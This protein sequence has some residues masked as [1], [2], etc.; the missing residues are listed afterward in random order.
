MTPIK[1]QKRHLA[2][3]VIIMAIS[4][5]VTGLL[6]LMVAFAITILP[7]IASG[8]IGWLVMLPAHLSVF[9]S[10]VGWVIWGVPIVA[11]LGGA[12][13]AD[14]F[15]GNAGSAAMQR[16]VTWFENSHPIAV[17]TNAYASQLG[18]GQIRYVGWFASDDINAFAMGTE[19][20]DTVI[21]F[22][23][24]AIERLD[25][26][27]FN[28]VIAHEVAHVAN[29]DMHRMTFARGVQEALTFFLV[30]RGLKK[31]AR[32]LFMP[33]AEIEVLRLS[34][35]REFAADHIAAQLTSPQA[36]VSVLETLQ[37]N[38]RDVADPVAL[39]GRVSGLLRTHPPL[40]ARIA[41]I[42]AN[43]YHARIEVPL[44]K[45]VVEVTPSPP[46]ARNHATITLKV[47]TSPT[48]PIAIHGV[49]SMGS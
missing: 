16:G 42:E 1:Y 23:S 13:M 39:N 18:I 10:A 29:N 9:A 37:N 17:Q 49:L 6:G 27:A 8:P 25:K 22:S 32:W 47:Q 14:R 40:D 45:P 30:F 21:A 33:I 34:R 4:A 36:V 24:A 2:P 28:A 41:A 12:L 46:M 44:E 48:D 11:V 5:M 15:G 26:E 19:P 3:T 20:K 35:Q 43:K 38:L 7:I 31:V